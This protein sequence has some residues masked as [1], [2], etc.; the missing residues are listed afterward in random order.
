MSELLE[1]IVEGVK[2]ASK[3]VLFYVLSG[4]AVALL[5]ASFIVPPMGVIDPS[6]LQ[7]VAWI[8]G[9]C[10]LSVV[11]YAIMRGI[12]SKLTHG[13]TS[14]EFNNPDKVSKQAD[15]GEFSDICSEAPSAGRRIRKSSKR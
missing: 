12:D 11:N 1:P 13:E 10:S 14:V 8:F 2:D 6:V 4:V 9:F 15:Y 5:I 3:N 7:G